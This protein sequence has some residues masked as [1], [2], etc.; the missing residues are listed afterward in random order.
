M[1]RYNQG[2]KRD[3]EYQAG[4]AWARKNVSGKSASERKALALRKGNARN[5]DKLRA[6]SPFW[7]GVYDFTA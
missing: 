6:S 3:D 4:V 5:D 1:A 2:S 7:M